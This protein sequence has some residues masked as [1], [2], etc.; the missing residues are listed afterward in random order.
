VR[1][2]IVKRKSKHSVPPPAPLPTSVTEAVAYLL[3]RLDPQSRANLKAM[4]RD[5]LIT[6][7]HGFGT[8]IRNELGLWGPSPIHQDPAVAGLFPD[9]LSQHLIERMW[10]ALQAEE[11]P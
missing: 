7:H 8:G 5:D 11:Q 4:R 2:L 10:E 3:A 1:G 6:L 9:D